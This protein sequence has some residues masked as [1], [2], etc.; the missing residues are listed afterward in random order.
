MLRW[1][2]GVA[3]TQGNNLIKRTFQKDN[4]GVSIKYALQ[5]NRL[6]AE[7][8]LRNVQD[9]F[10]FPLQTHP[11]WVPLGTPSVS[12]LARE[13]SVGLGEGEAAAGEQRV[14]GHEVLPLSAL[15]PLLPGCCVLAI[16][17]LEVLALTTMGGKRG[18][19]RSNIQKIVSVFLLA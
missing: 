18:N 16:H 13:L 8:K 10:H 2:G 9:L 5:R 4:S 7:E 17:L 11:I 14:E 1:H 3:Y 15:V 6:E 12:S 19:I